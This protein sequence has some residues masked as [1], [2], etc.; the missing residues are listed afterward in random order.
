MGDAEERLEVVAQAVLGA[1]LGGSV[2]V[3][4]IGGAQGC[5]DFDLVDSSGAVTHGVE[6]TSVQLPTARATRSA[7]RHLKDS[8][9]GLTVS[10]DVVVHEEAAPRSL[11]RE[12]AALLNRLSA[13]GVERFDSSEQDADDAAQHVIEELAS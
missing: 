5:R 13:L 8:D 10:W 2:V 9:V 12:A 4:D 11:L 1:A 6:V 3:R 7:I